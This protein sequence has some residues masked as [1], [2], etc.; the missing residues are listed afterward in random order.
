MDTLTPSAC[1]LT[2]GN[3]TLFGLSPNTDFDVDLFDGT[4]SSTTTYTSDVNGEIIIPNLGAGTYDV[5]VINVAT[6]CFSTTS[7]ETIDNPGAPNITPV[8]DVTV[9]ESYTLPAITGV[10]YGN[11]SYWTGTNG[12]G[13]NY[14]AG[15]AITSSGT[16]YM[17]DFN[18]I[19]SDEESFVITV[20]TT[21]VLDQPND[22]TVCD[23][24]ALEPI[25]GTNTTAGAA[26]Y[27]NWPSAGGT[28]ITGPLTSSQTVYVYDADGTCADS[29]SFV[30]TVDVTPTITVTDPAAVCEP[31]LVDAS[32]AATTDVGALTFYSDAG[33]TT[34]V[35]ETQ[36]NTGT[37]YVESVNNGCS[38]SDMINVTVNLLPPAPQAG[39]D[40]TYCSSWMLENMV[41]TGTGGTLTWYYDPASGSIGTGGTFAPD[42][43]LGTT[44]YYVTETLNG[45]EGPSSMVTITIENCE[46]TIPTAITPNGD[47][48]NDSWEVVDL[49]AVY[50]NNVVQIFNRWGNLIFEHSS[51]NG[52]SPYN[53]NQW[54]G[55]YEGNALPVGS[56]Y[57]VIQMNDDD[58][59]I[60]TGAVSIVLE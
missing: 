25:T 51:N 10:L 23:T 11:Q 30:V 46:I 6:G 20:N 27:D 48:V 28:V 9:C 40:S 39:I 44:D 16:I 56:Y 33:L 32:G 21:P 22:T 47:Q 29:V 52:S 54:D 60:A 26:H 1:D 12:T 35:D 15:D 37:Y 43:V 50:P 45:C 49:D 2:D 17:Y 31:N 38:S 36:L 41:A 59:T 13:T 8:S 53:S 57:Y 19:C 14:Q 24:Y 5:S 42:D 4:N 55:T 3:I 34:V 7:S 58:G 18:G